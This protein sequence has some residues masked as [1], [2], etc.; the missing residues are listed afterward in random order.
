MLLRVNL[1]KQK[2]SIYFSSISKNN[3]KIESKTNSTICTPRRGRAKQANKSTLIDKLKQSSCLHQ[4]FR[5]LKVDTM[6]AVLGVLFF[7]F[8]CAMHYSAKR[9]L[10]ITC[11]LSVSPS[12]RLSVCLRFWY[13]TFVRPICRSAHVNCGDTADWIRDPLRPPLSL[14]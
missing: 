4:I 6:A 13:C 1:Y 10:A 14:D 11:R 3:S 7:C 9:G 12:V 5:Q 2:K 8:Y